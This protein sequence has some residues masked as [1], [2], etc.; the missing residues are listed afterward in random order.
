MDVDALQWYLNENDTP[1][2]TP[3]TTNIHQ[4]LLFIVEMK[5]YVYQPL[6]TIE[7]NGITTAD[8]YMDIQT[9]GFV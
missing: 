2:I 8:R 9:L 1:P 7:I 5:M 6:Q 4:N 3:P